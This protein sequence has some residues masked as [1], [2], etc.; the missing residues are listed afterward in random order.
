MRSLKRWVMSSTKACPPKHEVFQVR[1]GKQVERRRRKDKEVGLRD[2]GAIR[3]AL[4][5]IL[6]LGLIG[7]GAELL[8]LGHYEGVLQWIPLALIGFAICVVP[9]YGMRQSTASVRAMRSTMA[10]FVAAGAVGVRCIIE[11]ILSFSAKWIPRFRDSRFSARR[12]KR[13]RRRRW[14]Q[15]A[16]P[17]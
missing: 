6:L 11:A 13:R 9:W 10:A 5:A 16:W 7:T 4:L 14:P 2:W 8:F 17:S 15:A 12:C 1:S 3:N